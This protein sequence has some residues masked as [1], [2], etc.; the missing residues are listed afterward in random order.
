MQKNKTGPLSYTI[1]TNQLEWIKELNVRPETIKILEENIGSKFVDIGLG[2][3]FFF[4]VWASKSKAHKQNK[5][6]ELH[7]TQNLL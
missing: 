4:L 2:N 6:V 7:E 5:Q 1:H 3:E